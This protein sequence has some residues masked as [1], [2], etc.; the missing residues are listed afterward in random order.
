MRAYASIRKIRGARLGGISK[1]TRRQGGRSDERG[2]Q[3]SA[4]PNENEPRGCP[5][6]A[7]PNP[8]EGA[9]RPSLRSQPE[10]PSRTLSPRTPPLL[11][12]EV[13]G[14]PELGSPKSGRR[15]RHPWT[16]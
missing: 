1:G 15:C 13:F 11:P 3:D 2:A 7:R 12:R 6:G 14:N 10:V 16:A 5:H 4:R 8:E 9:V